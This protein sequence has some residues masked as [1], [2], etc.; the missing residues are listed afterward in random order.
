MKYQMLLCYYKAMNK[1]RHYIKHEDN[2]KSIAFQTKNIQSYPKYR[3]IYK[4]LQIIH[5]SIPKEI[6]QLQ[7]FLQKN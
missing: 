3:K 6:I 4:Y 2:G 1:R 5:G 7:Q